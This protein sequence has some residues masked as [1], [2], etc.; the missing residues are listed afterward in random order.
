VTEHLEQQGSPEAELDVLTNSAV[1]AQ[2]GSETTGAVWR[3]QMRERDLDSNIIR[4]APDGRAVELTRGA[5]LWLPRRSRRGFT[6]GPDGLRY[7][8]VHQR[9]EAPTL[10]PV[11]PQ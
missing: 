4:L 10:L 8:T 11:M 6:A 3:L 1:S 7:L 9:R 2:N 5:L